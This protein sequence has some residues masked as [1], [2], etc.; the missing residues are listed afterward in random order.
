MRSVVAFILSIILTAALLVGLLY[1][2]VGNFTEFDFSIPLLSDS[3]VV[4]DNKE[5]PEFAEPT[6]PTPKPN[7]T[8]KEADKK[9]PTTTEKVEQTEPEDVEEDIKEIIFPES[10][11]KQAT[12]LF[13]GTDYR[14]DF[15]SGKRLT[16]DSI[17]LVKIDKVKKSFMF[18]AIP[19]NTVAG[20]TENETLFRIY[21]QQGTKAL[22]DSIHSLTGLQVEYVAVINTENCE[23]AFKE[24]GNVIYNV[25]CDM[26]VDEDWRNYTIDLEAGEQN[27]TPKQAV[28]LLRYNSF[29]GNSRHTH[30]RVLVSYVQALFKHITT[31]AF[32]ST[33][34]DWFGPMTDCF[35]SN[36]DFDD[37]I[38][39]F[40]MYPKYSSNSV[41]FPGY[42]KVSGDTTVFMPSVSEAITTYEEFK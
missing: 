4:L 26:S 13:I 33:S 28:A 19:A 10:N 32:A 14:K 18:S 35:E 1:A 7:S 29:A 5:S 2:L 11:D 42:S 3:T 6:K 23:K 24:I 37:Y 31:P 38:E 22:V 21:N 12:F 16:A 30:E 15:R 25:P 27:I 17:L 34:A 36:F 9:D 41:T 40:F 8:D 20:D 39:L